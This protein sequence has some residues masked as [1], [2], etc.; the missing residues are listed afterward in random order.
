[1][2][3][4]KYI[5]LILTIALIAVSCE[6]YDDY[7]ENRKTVAGFTKSANNINGIPEGGDKSME[8]EVFVSDISS[9]ARTFSITTRPIPNPDV[10]TPAAPENYRFDSTVTIPANER[11]GTMTV[12]GVDVSLTGDRTFFILAIEG[13]DD[14]VSGGITKMGIRN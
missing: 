6:S 8:L 7:D 1:M 12:T 11:S 14:V 3:K 4:L 2:K 5:T 10:D 13:G 9:A